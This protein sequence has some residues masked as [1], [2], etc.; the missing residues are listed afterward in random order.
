VNP[1]SPAP[2][3]PSTGFLPD[4]PD[5]IVEQAMVFHR[6]G[7]PAQ[8]LPLYRQALLVFPQDPQLYYL[9]GMTLLELG[10]P[11]AAL[12]DLESALQWAP[13]HADALL[14]AGL[15]HLQSGHQESA[16]QYMQRLTQ[17]APD[18]PRGFINLAGILL[19][20]N[21]LENAQKAAERAIQLLPASAEAWNNFGNARQ[22][23]GDFAQAEQAFRRALQSAPRDAKILQNL[24]DAL[25][26][27]NQL[28]AAEVIYRESL[29]IDP[30]LTGCWCNYGNL[31]GQMNREVEA[32]RAYQRALAVDPDASEAVVS[33]AGMQIEAGEE[34]AAIASLRPIVESGRATPEHVSVYAYA[35]RVKGDLDAAQALLRQQMAEHPNHKTLIYAFAHLALARKELL[36]QAIDM[37]RVWLRD[38]GPCESLADR[39]ILSIL[40]AQLYDKAGRHT[41]A[42]ASAA[43]AQ[44]LKGE[45]S[46]PVEEQALAAALERSFTMARLRRA[47]YGMAEET[48]PIF[49]VGMPRSG[50]SL[51]EQMLAGHPAVRPCGEVG[52]LQRITE[53]LGGGQ[54]TAW[55]M[56]AVELDAG[57]LEALAMR[58]LHVLGP[59]LDGAQYITDKMP[60]NF[61]NVGLI[62][63]LFPKA[64]VIH[65][66]RD[67]RDVAVSIFL[68]EFSGHHPY[69]HHIEDIAQHLLFYRRCM[70]LWRSRMPEGCFYELRYEDLVTSPESQARALL[71]F[72][73][74]SWDAGVLKPESVTRAVLTS[75]RFQVQE[76]I[77]RRAAGRW[78]AYQREL[79]PLT[80]I[81]KSAFPEYG[82]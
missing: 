77:H 23:L 82:L 75:S 33:L 12:Q 51:L 13:A 70:Q 50:T 3:P 2:L 29:A 19:Q 65:I 63:L 52:E 45:R 54:E 26:V 64:R 37:A 59:A 10:D 28:S 47:P 44:R 4:A 43:A 76:S 9:A 69:A 38:R 11:H 20:R 32:R 78:Q 7:Q 48:R 17:I 34:A 68:R 67:P 46:Q 56:R 31:L 53:E 74:L 61:V 14:Q 72:L 6:Q 81:L 66:Q 73:G 30:Q 35:L 55:P 62:H 40:L 80:A 25:R 15:L 21:D 18:E 27:Q 42:F 49:I 60:H 79:V 58:Y 57:S 39:T 8:A 5:A 16:L 41:E 71:D 1:I 22:R 36:P 24:A